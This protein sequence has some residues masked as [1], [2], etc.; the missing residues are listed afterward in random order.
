MKD[1][2][3]QI[4]NLKLIEF[5]DFMLGCAKT[6]SFLKIY[7]RE[8]VK[9]RKDCGAQVFSYTEVWPSNEQDFISQFK[10]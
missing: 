4:I 9:V 3:S 5:S 7:D 6:P 10:D 2:I 8:R 1:M